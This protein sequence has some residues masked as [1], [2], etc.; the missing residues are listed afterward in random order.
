MTALARAKARKFEQWNQKQFT[1]ASGTVAYKGGRCVILPGTNTV[2]PAAAG[3]KRIGIGWFMENMDATSAAK[4]VNVYLDREVNVE[5]FANSG[6][7]AASANSLGADAYFEDDQTVGTKAENFPYAGMIW[8]FSA[9]DGV[10]VE[11]PAA[12][13][14]ADERGVYAPGAFVSNDLVLAANPPSNV[15]IDVPTTGAASTV[16]LP[17]TVRDGTV[18]IFFADGVKNG[19]T[20]Q[21][22]D[23]TGPVNLTTALTA[24]KRHLVHCVALGGKWAANAYVSP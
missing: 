23:A 13:L 2:A 14:K 3:S 5:W 15:V 8:G 24:S 10:A 12:A 16:T 9:T 21:Y 4:L 6:T 18:L 11:A 20:V 22:R 19:H 17:A 7:N 1:L